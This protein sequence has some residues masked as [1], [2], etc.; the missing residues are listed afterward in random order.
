MHLLDDYAK[1]HAGK[2]SSSS[3]DVLV[4]HVDTDLSHEAGREDT[5]AQ[6]MMT[7]YREKYSFLTF[8][9]V[10]LSCVLEVQTVDWGTLPLEMEGKLEDRLREM[11]ERLPS[12]T[13]KADVMRLMIRHLLLHMVMKDKRCTALLL[14]HTTTTLAA[15]TLS[16]VANGRGHSVPWQ[17]NDGPYTVCNYSGSEVSKTTYPIHYPLRE[18]FKAEINTYISLTP[19]LADISFAKDQSASV[20]SHKDT[21]I[22]EVMTRYFEGVEEPLS[23]IVAN[24]VRTTGKLDRAGGTG[25]LCGLCGVTLNEQGDS[26]W[27]GDMGEEVGGNGKLC[28][29]CK[30]SVNG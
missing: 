16:E 1:L 25:D 29:G 20:V 2:K 30:R 18:I 22:E 11:F 4:V 21:S 28:Y 24:V 26:R 13:S 8:E 7:K 23:G 19:S 12:V 5:A 15:L 10:H 3:F 9:C 27:A 6:R 17:V 14:G